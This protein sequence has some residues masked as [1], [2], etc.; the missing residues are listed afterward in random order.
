M[1]FHIVNFEYF[2]K[3]LDKIVL[4]GL[5][6]IPAPRIVQNKSKNYSNQKLS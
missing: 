5:I 6:L 4:N 2:L 1:K 3:E